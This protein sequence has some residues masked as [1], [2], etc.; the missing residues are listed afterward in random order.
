MGLENSTVFRNLS[1]HN[2]Q[3]L[4]HL[5]NGFTLDLRDLLDPLK[6]CPLEELD[7]S[8]NALRTIIPGL[9]S[10][11]PK[12]E[13]LVVSNNLIVPLMTG[14]FFME[15]LLH[16]NLIEADFSKQ[17]FSTTRK[18]SSNDITG[19]RIKRLQGSSGLPG[20]MLKKSEVDIDIAVYQENKMCLDQVLGNLCNLF[21]PVCESFRERCTKDHQIFCDLVAIYI[22]NSGAIPC[23]FI[24]P[25]DSMIN[26][27]C[28][29][30]FV[31]PMT[32]SLKRMYLQK[33]NNYDE[34]LADALF[35]EETCFHHNNSM[36]ILDF[37]YNREHGYADIDVAFSTPIIGWNS[38]KVLKLS[39]NEM[40]HP[41]SDLGYNLPQIEVFDLSYNLLDL[42]GKYG[43]FLDGATSVREL[44][45]AGNRV[46]NIPRNRFSTLSQTTNPHSQQQWS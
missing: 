6:N 40:Q 15:I 26:E 39:H 46:Q 31:F 32:G 24:P 43:E 7:I 10:K 18:S 22:P 34:I 19:N 25:F 20:Q 27:S 17:G 21:S 16:P 23:E 1:L 29:G 11:A 41:S 44:N 2:T 37:S 3:T 8:Y 38:M 13:K 42:Q 28:G 45:L 33:V 5:H 14:A 4:E 36:E 30:C 12:L 35:K 9:I